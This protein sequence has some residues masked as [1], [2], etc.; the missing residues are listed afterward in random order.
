[1]KGCEAFTI[2]LLSGDLE[3]LSARVLGLTED[4]AGV[5]LLTLPNWQSGLAAFAGSAQR[6]TTAPAAGV[7]II[8]RE[9]ARA[10]NGIDKTNINAIG[11]ASLAME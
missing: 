10:K 6:V 7:S 2:S 5:M 9:S 4:P 11:A 1:M 8:P 3:D